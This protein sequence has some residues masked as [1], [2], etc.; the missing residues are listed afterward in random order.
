MGALNVFSIKNA[1]KTRLWTRSGATARAMWYGTA[2]CLPEPNEYKVR[3]RG[4]V[5]ATVSFFALPMYN[6]CTF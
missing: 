4:L 1:T 3:I 5:L 2:I 6:L